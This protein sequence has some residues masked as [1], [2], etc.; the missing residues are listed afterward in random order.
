[1]IHVLTV[2]II[3]LVAMLI[4]KANTEHDIR[5][6]ALVLVQETEAVLASVAR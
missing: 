2:A 6:A 4:R 5:I 3:G 1:M